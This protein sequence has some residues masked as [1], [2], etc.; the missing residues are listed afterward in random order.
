MTK[1]FLMISCAVLMTACS[2]ESGAGPTSAKGGGDPAL[3][4]TLADPAPEGELALDVEVLAEGLANPWSIAF[5]P[6][7]DI[8]VS[9]RAGRLRIIRDGNLMPDPVSG[10][11]EIHPGRQAGLFDIL[12]HPNFSENNW[13]YLAYAHGTDR[14]NATRI[15]R[16]KYADGALGEVEVLYDAVPEKDT[17]HHYGGRLVW[18]G[19]GKLYATIGEGSKYKEKAQDMTSSFGSV[20]RLNEDGTIPDDNP[21]FGEGTRPELFTKGHRNGQGFTY[22]AERGFLWETEHGPRGGDE[23][24]IIE[25]GN[26]YGWPLASYGIDYNGAKITPF[27]EYEGT[28][29]PVKYWTPSIAV[30]GLAVYRGDLFADWEGDLLVGA[31][32]GAALHHIEMDGNKPVDEARYL[33]SR[34]E[35]VRDVR[36]GPDGAIY[37]ATEMTNDPEPTGKVLRLTPQ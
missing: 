21:V 16:A 35:R 12:P 2:G 32:A 30:S 14:A 19:D 28:T 1:R 26:N 18:G 5:L 7:G 20:V 11:P 9:E 6:N 24:N 17:N 3:Q 37:V 27:T 10:L 34:G 25:A 4:E 22:D 29:Q 15:A 33:L 23:L 36:V 8:L 31:M 13:L